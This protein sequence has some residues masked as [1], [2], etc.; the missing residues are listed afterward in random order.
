MPC[1]LHTTDFGTETQPFMT[2]KEQTEE[3]VTKPLT[4]FVEKVLSYTKGKNPEKVNK[5]ILESDFISRDLSWLQFNFRVLDQARSDKRNLF[6]KMKFLAITA[7]NFDEFFMIRVGSLY[8]YIDFNRERMDYSGLRE[9]QFRQTLLT[10]SQEFYNA[11]NLLFNNDLRPQFRKNGFEIGRI[12]DLTE[13]ETEVVFDFFKRTIHPMLTPMMLDVYHTFPIVLNKTL[14]FGVITRMEDNPKNPLRLSF[15]QVPQNLSRFYEI[16]RGEYILL[17]P[18]EEIIRWQMDKLFRNI[19]IVSTNLFRV[20][21]NGDISIEESDD[22]ESDLVDEVRR[23]LS[24]RKTGRVVRLEIEDN[25]SVHLIKILKERWD[26]DNDNIFVS[27]NIIDYT[28]LWQIINHVDFKDRLPINL[29]QVQPLFYPQEGRNVSMFDILKKQDLL[30]HHPFN[31]M[32]PVLRM[33]EEAATDPHVL[34]I[35]LTIYRLARHSRIIDA[36]LKAA[37]NGKYV[38]VLFEVKARF[39]EENN[40]RQAQRLQKAGCFVIY[41][42]G[43]YKTH[44]KLCLIVRKEEDKVTRFVHLASGN[45]NEETSKIYTDIGLLSSKEIYANDVSEFFNV[46]TGHSKPDQYEYLITSPRDM[47]NQLIALIRQEAANVQKGLTGGIVIKLNSLED[48]ST[49]EEL[50]KA[51]QAGVKIKLIVRGMCCLRPG[52]PGLS[53][54]IEVRSIVGDFLEHTRLYYFN[55]AGEPLV[56]CGSADMMNRSF[57]R[58]LESLFLIADTNLRRMVINILHFNLADNVNSYIMLEDGSYVQYQLQ[59][60][61]PEVNIHKLFYSLKEEELSQS[62]LF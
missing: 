51:S 60:G 54:N 33:L 6:E 36:L 46:I 8:N 11:Q 47:R 44:T 7:S 21:R 34:S 49:I 2:L 3:L 48:Q 31:S 1:S 61:E 24:N 52:R 62:C 59:E 10:E 22:I 29:P 53:E 58:R 50:Y 17:L 30:L 14:T 16:N 12:D 27:N 41:G 20:I 25:Y 18:V 57:D 4:R 56:Y 28:C 32:E 43:S 9:H 15:V 26:I 23:Q 42:L 39:D 55:N 38:S 5:S 40:I 13:K 19:E 35:K 37:E 45:Y